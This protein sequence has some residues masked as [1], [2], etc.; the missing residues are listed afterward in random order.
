MLRRNFARADEWLRARG[1]QRDG[2]IGNGEA[3]LMRASGLV[4]VAV[5]ELE[6]DPFAFLHARDARCR[7]CELAWESV[8]NQVAR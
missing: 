5:A 7:E 2:T 4:R 3:R 1:L 8:P 6:C